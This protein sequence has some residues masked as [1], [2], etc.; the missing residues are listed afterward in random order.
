MAFVAFARS[1]PCIS[2]VNV[3]SFL[4]GRKA[5]SFLTPLPLPTFTPHS[6]FPHNITNNPH[7]QPL[8]RSRRTRFCSLKHLLEAMPYVS[9]AT[10]IQ[11]L[12]EV[13]EEPPSSWT[14]AQ[15]QARWDE[16]SKVKGSETEKNLQDQLQELRQMGRKKKSE[17]AQ[18]LREKEILFTPTDTIV[19][20]LAKG[21]QKITEEHEPSDNEVLGFGKY[22]TK[23]MMEVAENYGAYGEWCKTTMKEE[24]N[25]SWRLRRFVIYYENFLARKAFNKKSSAVH[26]K[27]RE[28]QHRQT[29][30]TIHQVPNA[31]RADGYTN[32]NMAF[33]H[34]EKGSHVSDS[35]FAVVSAI[36]TTAKSSGSMDESEEVRRLKMELA[37]I[38]EEKADL[39]HQVSRAK[40][41]KE[42]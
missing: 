12:K 28:S 17:L 31:A 4:I 6:L 1:S 5:L 9:K 18:Y 36:P 10:W 15:L 7:Q 24:P 11:R 40:G 42:M 8:Q 32:E 25:H 35:S 37:A 21:E 39:E 26:G 20:M 16:I 14:V 38:K 41:R 22:G 13:G 2:V 19:Q 30:E 33:E 34:E 23:T 27:I 29:M 3:T